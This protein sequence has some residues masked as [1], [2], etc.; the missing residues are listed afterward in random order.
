M[1]NSLK[2]RLPDP[3]DIDQIKLVATIIRD[4]E[5]GCAPGDWDRVFARAEFDLDAYSASIVRRIAHTARKVLA[6]LEE[7]TRP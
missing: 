5:F 2:G 3:N 4:N 7:A 1:S 6:A